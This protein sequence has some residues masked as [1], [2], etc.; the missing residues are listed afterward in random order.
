[1]PAIAPNGTPWVASGFVDVSGDVAFPTTP[2]IEFDPNIQ[3]SSVL[4][5][6]DGDAASHIEYSL[7][8]TDV[9]GSLKTSCQ[10]TVERSQ[11]VAQPWRQFWFRTVAGAVVTVKVEV[12]SVFKSFGR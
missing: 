5:V 6:L 4:I 2:Q 8:G 12:T 9:C 1:M 10:K 7:N 3:P 11:M